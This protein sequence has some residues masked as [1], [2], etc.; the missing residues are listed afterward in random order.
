MDQEH[1]QKIHKVTEQTHWR[2]QDNLIP[3]AVRYDE[4]WVYD[5]KSFINRPLTHMVQLM[6]CLSGSAFEKITSP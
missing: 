4:T 2:I 3:A 5:L 6:G 1:S